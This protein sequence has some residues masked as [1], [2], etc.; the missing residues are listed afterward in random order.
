MCGLFS[1][2]G[3]TN[4]DEDARVVAGGRVWLAVLVARAFSEHCV[5]TT[6]Q[7]RQPARG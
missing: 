3:Y 5:L 4:T 7:Q 6:P 2:A 1:P